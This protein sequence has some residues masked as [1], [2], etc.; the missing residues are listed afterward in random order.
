MVMQS[1]NASP[2]LHLAKF[3]IMPK[4]NCKVRLL[5][6]FYC[7]LEFSLVKSI[8]PKRFAWC[9]NTKS[10]SEQRNNLYVEQTDFLYANAEDLI[11]DL[12]ATSFSLVSFL[13]MPILVDRLI[14]DLISNIY[15]FT[16]LWTASHKRFSFWLGMEPEFCL[17]MGNMIDLEKEMREIGRNI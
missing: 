9:V 2:M 14:Y 11:Q 1:W 8:L 3:F 17:W 15:P 5:M 10:T 12:G 7:T 13:H 6:P 16:H 4:Q